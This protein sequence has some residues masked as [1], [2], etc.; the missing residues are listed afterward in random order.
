[1]TIGST[2]AT[3]G[4]VADRQGGPVGQFP[5]TFSWGAATAAY[6]IEGAV[7]EDGRT[8]SIWDTFAAKPGKV[9]H[10]HTGARAADHYHRYA[11]DVA[12]MRELGLGSYRFSVAWPR[13]QPTG[14][15]PAN[16]TGTGFY[17]RLVDALLEAGIRPMLTLY[18]WDL[19]QELEEAGGWA[20]RDT[21][22]RFADYAALVATRLGDRV[23]LWTT[24]NE[25]WCSA[26]LGYA[27]G[28]HAPGRTE[29][30]TAM[31]VAHHLL[32]GHGLAVGVLRDTLPAAAEV[33]LVLN[34]S[35]IRCVTESFTD[36]EAARRIDGLLNRLFLD[37]VLTGS[38][39]ADVIDD[40]VA[41]TD[42]AFVEP[43][44]LKHISAPI[45]ALGLNYYHPTVVGAAAPSHTAAPTPWPGCENIRFDAAPGPLTAMG[46]PVDASGL[47]EVL[48]RLRR[49]YPHLPPLLVTENGAA[50][51]DEVGPD[52][53]VHDP[54]R[55]EYLRSHLA[56][57]RE[58]LTL[59]VDVRGY[60]VWSLL[61]NFEWSH[62]Y[63]QRFGIVRVDY[64]TQ[65]RTLKSSAHWY[66]EVIRR[67]ALP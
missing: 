53:S 3:D 16:P 6:Q 42:W 8:P 27:S 39:P 22:E 12:I 52:G 38:Y 23:P 28:Q 67:N 51:A 35:P 10:G 62:G 14:R 32:L 5:P 7:A 15:G 31:A 58:A 44:D 36:V 20:N 65:R 40:T 41:L 60:F 29:P 49:D 56:A 13:V 66:A 18:H 17:D 9:A 54:A 4:E 2:E 24:V 33:S 26:F 34:M 19:P 63:G 46:W 43:A 48:L 47:S 61:D 57:V 59:G 21:S 37:P 11:D 1:M 55:I 30:A 25:P 45:D 64:P 50:F